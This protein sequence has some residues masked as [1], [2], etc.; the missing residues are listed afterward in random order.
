MHWAA[1]REELWGLTATSSPGQVWMRL[2]LVILVIQSI[3]W[4]WLP[5]FL[6][7]TWLLARFAAHSGA[8]WKSRGNWAHLVYFFF[9]LIKC[10]LFFPFSNF[11]F[12]NFHWHGQCDLRR[13]Y[14]SYSYA[15]FRRNLWFFLVHF[16]EIF[17][18][19]QRVNNRRI[20][21]A[22]QHEDFKSRTFV[23]SVNG[24]WLREE[25]DLWVLVLNLSVLLL[26]INFA[27]A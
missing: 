23:I 24:V 20:M 16:S 6:I 17:G 11:V 3:N 9:C 27:S 13:G 5:W 22:R 1:H 26:T 10:F 14:V 15:V 8:M 7:V 19:F 21:C 4:I 25:F 2:A 18:T 12:H